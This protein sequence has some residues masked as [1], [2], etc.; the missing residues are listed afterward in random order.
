MYQ[1]PYTPEEI[2]SHYPDKADRLLADPVHA[3]R[4][5]TGIELIHEEPTTEEQIRIWENWNEMTDDMRKESD[6][7]SIELF[8]KDNAS[9]HEEIMRDRT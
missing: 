5:E 4:A 6:Q 8:G 7:K 3:W 9:H 1:R 2:R